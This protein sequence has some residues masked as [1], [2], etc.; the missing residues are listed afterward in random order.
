MAAGTILAVMAARLHEKIRNFPQPGGLLS[1]PRRQQGVRL[2][3]GNPLVMK[4]EA[5]SRCDFPVGPR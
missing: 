2:H 5:V 4:D 1:L 3:L